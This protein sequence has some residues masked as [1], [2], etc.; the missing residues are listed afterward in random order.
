MITNTAL[1]FQFVHSLVTMGHCVIKTVMTEYDNG[2][3]IENPI[4]AFSG[5]LAWRVFMIHLPWHTQ[6]PTRNEQRGG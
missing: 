3:S 6:Q 5:D 1:Q 4:F 2:H